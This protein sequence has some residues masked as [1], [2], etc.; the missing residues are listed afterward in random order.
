[1]VAGDELRRRDRPASAALAADATRCSRRA[2]RRCPATPSREVAGHARASGV[3]IGGM[4]AAARAL[5]ARD[6]QPVRARAARP[7]PRRG[8]AW[9]SACRGSSPACSCSPRGTSP[10]T[11]RTCS[12]RTRSR[13]SRCRSGSR[14]RSGRGARCAGPVASWMALGASTLLL[15]VLKLLPA[16]DQDTSVPM[17]LFVPVNVGCALAHCCCASVLRPRRSAGVTAT[18][19]RRQPRDYGDAR[20]PGVAER[21]ERQLLREACHVVAAS[22]VI[23]CFEHRCSLPTSAAVP[24]SGRIEWRS[25]GEARGSGIGDHGSPARSAD[26]LCVAPVRSRRSARAPPSRRPR[27]SRSPRKRSRCTMFTIAA[28]SVRAL[29][30]RRLARDGLPSNR[31]ASFAR[32]PLCA[33]PTRPSL[34][35]AIG[36]VM[37]SFCLGLYAERRRAGCRRSGAERAGVSGTAA[38]E[39]GERIRGKASARLAG[40]PSGRQLRARLLCG[41]RRVGVCASLAAATRTRKVAGAAR[42]EATEQARAAESMERGA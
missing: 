38:V 35:A 26:Q 40:V 31:C 18:R 27:S 9:C 1:M 2:G 33:A 10:T 13:S 17:A 29:H 8:R 11:T 37:L 12:S 24:V 3:L 36:D 19:D 32:L 22:L 5:A 16:F 41:R 14:R 23:A 34:G 28:P 39:A 20:R 42:E 6:R 21:F 7:A 4:R 30:E 25:R 15:L